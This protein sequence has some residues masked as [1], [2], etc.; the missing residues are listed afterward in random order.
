MSVAINRDLCTSC[1]SCARVCAM[2]LFTKQDDTFSVDENIPCMRCGHCYSVCPTGAI[3]PRYSGVA[4][5]LTQDGESAID[6][7][8]LARYIMNNRS[9]RLFKDTA[10]PLETITEL[11]EVTRFSASGTNARPVRWVVV[12]DPTR[13]QAFSKG[14]L[15]WLASIPQE[16]M[17]RSFADAILSMQ[18]KQKDIIS[19]GAPALILACAEKNHIT[20]QNKEISFVDC[21][22]ALTHLDI[23]SSAYG[24]GTCWDG[25]AA[26]F[27]GMN[28]ELAKPL[29][30]PDE[31]VFQYAMM[32]GYPDITY[33]RIP[34][35]DPAQV[36][37]AGE[38]KRPHFVPP[39]EE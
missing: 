21:I 38:K 3:T 11:L 32:I 7:A 6:K 4:M 16:H 24:L 31:L 9:I 18:S 34:P 1:G 10:V 13:V 23:I 35:R 25:F 14:C 20:P 39:I 27:I 29:D 36:W 22:I 17:L 37:V 19:R 26:I 33:K 30:I 8:E 5:P 28:P 15:D 12:H 2:Y